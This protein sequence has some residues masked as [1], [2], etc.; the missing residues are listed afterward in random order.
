MIDCELFRP[1][2]AT[3]VLAGGM[4]AF[5]QVAPAKRHGLVPRLVVSRKGQDL[6]NTQ[7]EPD[8][9]DKWLAFAWREF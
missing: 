3:A 5:K 4:I 2:L 6:R 9:P 7:M 8:G 1:G